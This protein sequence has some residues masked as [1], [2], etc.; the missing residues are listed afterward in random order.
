VSISATAQTSSPMALR[1]EMLEP[2]PC[3]M[4]KLLGTRNVLQT[5]LG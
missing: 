3:H 1:Y 4:K 5:A 2:I